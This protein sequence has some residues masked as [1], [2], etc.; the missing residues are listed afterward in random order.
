[1]QFTTLHYYT[2]TLYNTLH[3]YKINYTSLQLERVTIYKK[4][5]DY[6]KGGS[7]VDRIM[8]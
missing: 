6:P 8:T 3:K 5:I 7:Q 2:L 1:M 4:K